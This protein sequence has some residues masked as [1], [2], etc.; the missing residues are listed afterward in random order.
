MGNISTPTVVSVFLRSHTL[1]ISEKILARERE[2]R[3]M[4][5]GWCSGRLYHKFEADIYALSDGVIGNTTPIKDGPNCRFVLPLSRLHNEYYGRRAGAGTMLQEES[6]AAYARRG[7]VGRSKSTCTGHH[8]LVLR[9][10]SDYYGYS[11]SWPC[12]PQIFFIDTNRGSI[13]MKT[14]R[15]NV[16][17]WFASSLRCKVPLSRSPFWNPVNGR[18]NM[19]PLLTSLSDTGG[20]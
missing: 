6:T 14:R 1:R 2:R 7:L 5:L 10:F 16:R 12:S 20:K 17:V 8:S 15:H 4:G 11:R 13:T 19:W 3:G 18:V 9:I